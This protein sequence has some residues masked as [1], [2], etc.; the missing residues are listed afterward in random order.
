MIW[1]GLQS[2][3]LN[4][5]RCKPYD[6]ETSV[7]SQGPRQ[8]IHVASI[9]PYPMRARWPTVRQYYSCLC[10]MEGSMSTRCVLWTTGRP[11]QMLMDRVVSFRCEPHIHWRQRRHASFRCQ[12]N[13]RPCRCENQYRGA[14]ASF[15]LLC[16][17]ISNVHT[18]KPQDVNACVVCV[19]DPKQKNRNTARDETKRI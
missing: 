4:L 16:K 1:I 5:Y 19:Q 8:S 18:T 7:R 2:Y 11:R 3:K 17:R 13:S 12:Y 14:G 15:F 6:H 10:P 9:E